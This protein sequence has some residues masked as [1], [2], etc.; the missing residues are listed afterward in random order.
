M[1]GFLAC[2]H[3]VK[4]NT[5]K[6]VCLVSC[7]KCIQCKTARR[8][9]TE[10]LL[11]LETQAHKYCELI[12][13][14]YNDDYIPWVDLSA[15]D[16][17]YNSISSELDYLMRCLHPIHFG[18]RMKQMYNPRTKQYYEVRD[19]EYIKQRFTSAFGTLETYVCYDTF[20][21]TQFYLD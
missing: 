9:K 13:L 17:R 11:S 18:D 6:G 2:N 15:I 8:R 12:N 4:V 1:K 3:P 16:G 10:L 20:D 14:T 5:L 19:K 21:V 7:G